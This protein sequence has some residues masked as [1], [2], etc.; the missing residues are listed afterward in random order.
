MDSEIESLADIKH[1]HPVEFYLHLPQPLPMWNIKTEHE[2][3]SIEVKDLTVRVEKFDR[4][5]RIQAKLY[6]NFIKCK[7]CDYALRVSIG[8]HERSC[9]KNPLRF[10]ELYQC[11]LC[12]CFLSSKDNIRRHVG[13]HLFKRHTCEDCGS[14]FTSTTHLTRH[15][16]TINDCCFCDVKSLCRI[17][18]SSHVK[19]KHSEEKFYECKL[20]WK[21]FKAETDFMSHTEHCNKNSRCDDCGKVFK[22]FRDLLMHRNEKITRTCSFCQEEFPCKAALKKHKTDQHENK[23]KCNI[24]HK[25]FEIYSKLVSHRKSEHDRKIKIKCEECK[26]EFSCKPSLKH[27]QVLERH[28]EF[29]S[30][31]PEKFKCDKCNKVYMSKSVLNDHQRNVHVD[32][33]LRTCS[34]CQF[35]SASIKCLNSHVKAKHP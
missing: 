29:A 32:K 33:K 11:D 7:F 13:T 15:R 1:E 30:T 27:H 6:E 9:S 35:I 21:F 22:M 4:N 8:Y 3:L 19:Q 25:I 17:S 18:L 24:C 12:S 26:R 14:A 16:L 2:K 5:H 20:C 23:F 10:K 28:G 34:I 31:E